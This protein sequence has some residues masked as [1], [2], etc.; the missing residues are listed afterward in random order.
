MH[1]LAGRRRVLSEEVEE[2]EVVFLDVMN[3]ISPLRLLAKEIG[4][5]SGHQVANYAQAFRHIG[6]NEDCPP[7]RMGEVDTLQGHRPKEG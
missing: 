4:P 6:L 7:S 5:A 1:L 2:T 3:H